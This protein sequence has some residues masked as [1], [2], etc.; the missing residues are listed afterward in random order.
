MSYDFSNK[1]IYDFGETIGPQR[2]VT[3]HILIA[4]VGFIGGHQPL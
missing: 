1:R 2:R 3:L 4:I